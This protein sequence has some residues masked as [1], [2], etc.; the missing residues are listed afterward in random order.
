MLQFLGIKPKQQYN[1]QTQ[2][3]LPFLILLVTLLL[4]NKSKQTSHM[5]LGNCPT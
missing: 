2:L 4:S 1:I 5:F 3:K